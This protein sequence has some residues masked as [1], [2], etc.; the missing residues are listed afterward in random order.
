MGVSFDAL[1]TTSP[2]NAPTM[3][4]TTSS[5]ASV[6]TTFPTNSPPTPSPVVSPTS[7]PPTSSPVGL[8]TSSPVGLPTWSPLGSPTLAPNSIDCAAECYENPGSIFLL[9]VKNKAPVYETCEDLAER[10]VRSRKKICKKERKSR[11]GFGPASVHCRVTCSE[12]K[13][14]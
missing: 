9:K 11:G 13:N 4:P 14:E 6:P 7:L 2:T 10:S 5:T 8:P 1:S 12:W 3:S